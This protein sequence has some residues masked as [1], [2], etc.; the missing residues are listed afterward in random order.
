MIANETD[1]NKSH[2]GIT[3]RR[4]PPPAD[5]PLHLL[6]CHYFHNAKSLGR[7]FLMA[8]SNMTALFVVQNAIFRHISPFVMGG[9]GRLEKAAGLLWGLA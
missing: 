1:R 4:T 8:P 6:P 5:K 9:G 7:L 3:I 2:M